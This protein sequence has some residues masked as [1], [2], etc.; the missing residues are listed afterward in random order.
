V[1]ILVVCVEFVDPQFAESPVEVFVRPIEADVDVFVDDHIVFPMVV[2]EEQDV[3]DHAV[4][5]IM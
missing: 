5:L 1:N 3:F 4:Y 2:F